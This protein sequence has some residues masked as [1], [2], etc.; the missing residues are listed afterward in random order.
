MRVPIVFSG[1]S[2]I[3]AIVKVF[4][5]REENVATDI[6]KLNATLALTAPNVHFLYRS[7]QILQG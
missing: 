1:Q 4:V 7:S 6:V 3:D 5:V 2:L